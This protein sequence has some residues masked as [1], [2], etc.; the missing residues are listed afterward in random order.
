MSRINVSM[1]EGSDAD[2]LTEDEFNKAFSGVQ[3]FS[4][5]AI[6]RFDSDIQSLI[7]KGASTG[8]TSEESD[9]LI[10]AQRDRSHLVKK[11]IIRKD[12]RRTTKWVRP[13]EAHK[14]SGSSVSGDGQSGTNSKMFKKDKEYKVSLSGSKTHP[15]YVIEAKDGSHMVDMTFTSEDEA[16]KFASNRGVE[17][18]NDKSKPAD[19][20]S[21]KFSVSYKLKT[22]GSNGVT[23]DTVHNMSVQ[24]SSSKEAEEIFRKYD[25]NSSI[26]SVTSEDD[27]SGGSSKHNIK[28]GDSVTTKHSGPFKVTKVDGEYISF[29]NATG[30]TD[31]YHYTHLSDAKTGEALNA[32]E[33]KKE[34]IDKYNTDIK[35]KDLIAANPYLKASNLTDI[36]DVESALGEVKKLL[37]DHPSSIALKQILARVESKKKQLSTKTKDSVKIG[38]GDTVKVKDGIVGAGKKGT[39]VEVRGGFVVVET[40]AGN[41]SFHESDLKRVSGSKL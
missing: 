38:E 19:S 23:S 12:G 4:E 25:K 34:L 40:K 11:V 21:G 20:V 24:A 39:V 35:V 22:G 29:K 31:E 30:G 1:F 17:L 13:T 37:K 15:H 32:G 10:K 18:S 6:A 41:M 3:S 7:S 28:V 33:R 26:V 8:L 16:K 27:K 36:A 2:E 9:N 14:D 5:D